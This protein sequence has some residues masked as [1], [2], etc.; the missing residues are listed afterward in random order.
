MEANT[1]NFRAANLDHGQQFIVSAINEKRPIDVSQLLDWLSW[2]CSA[3]GDVSS[4]IRNDDGSVTM[5][6]VYPA[7]T[8]PRARL[9]GAI[10]AMTTVLNKLAPHI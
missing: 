3:Q 10:L 7:S 5:G 2:A 1:P 4:L 8:Q 6:E 9:A